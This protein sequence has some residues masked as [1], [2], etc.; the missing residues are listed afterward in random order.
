MGRYHYEE[1]HAGAEPAV[2]HSTIG[3]AVLS[4]DFKSVRAFTERD[5]II[6]W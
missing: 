3:V 5:N 4:D 2:N 6:Q 1:A